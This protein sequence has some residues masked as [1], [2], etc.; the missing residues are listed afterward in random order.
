MTIAKTDRGFSLY[1]EM[2]DSRGCNIRVIESSIAGDPHIYV[3]CQNQGAYHTDA[4]GADEPLH[5]TVDQAQ[6]LRDALNLFIGDAVDPANWRNSPGYVAA[7]SLG[8]E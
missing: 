2:K 5:L 8:D 6:E 4:I 7:W 3:F 1:C